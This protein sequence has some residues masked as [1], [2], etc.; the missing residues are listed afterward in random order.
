MTMTKFINT[1]PHAI[2]VK[3]NEGIRT[4]PPS[5][6]NIRLNNESV[7][8]DTVDGINL[9][10][11][12]VTPGEVPNPVKDT[13]YIV[14]AMVRNA[15]P[16]RRDFISPKTDGTAKRNEKGHIEYVIGFDVNP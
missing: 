5:G 15:F 8:V 3:D 7:H 16:N 13:Y 4:F 12:T 14:S 9:F 11:N 1:T 6:I 2:N 10:K